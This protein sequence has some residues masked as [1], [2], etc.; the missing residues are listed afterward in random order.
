M[1]A[2]T[3][4]ALWYCIKQGHTPLAVHN[5]FRGLLDDAI[6]ELSWLGVDGWMSRGGSELGTNRTLP[7]IDLGAVASRFQEDNIHGQ[8][9][10]GGF[11]AFHALL[12]LETGRK[13]YPTFHIPTVHLPATISNNVPVAEFSLGSDTSLN[14][15]VDEYDATKQ[16]AS[17]CRN[18]G[19]C[20]RD[21]GRQVWI[22]IKMER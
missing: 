8:M 7:D 22:T 13:Y 15:L 4:V 10:I 16:S 6:H 12:I 20:R 17:A 19:V 11:E 14:A 5:G 1:N 18:R 2:A 3:R 9:L 21:A